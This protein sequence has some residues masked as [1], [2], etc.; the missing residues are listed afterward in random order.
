[1]GQVE[2]ELVELKQGWVAV[3]TGCTRSSSSSSSDEED[4]AY[5]SSS[6]FRVEDS[7]SQTRVNSQAATLASSVDL[8]CAVEEP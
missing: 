3:L 7:S 1:M 6:F 5:A 2:M 4:D 8:L